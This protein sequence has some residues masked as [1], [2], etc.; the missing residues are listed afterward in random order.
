M[1]VLVTGGT[2]FIGIHL[3]AALVARGW[4][5]RCLVRATSNRQPLAVYPVDYVVGHLQDDAAL[6]QAVQGMDLIFH[7]AGAT[8]ARTPAEFDRINAEGTQRLLAACAAAGTALRSFVYVSSIAAAG[9]SAS[10]APV[11]E[12][13]PPRPVG[14]YGKSKRRAEEA[15]L[16]AGAHMPVTVLRPSAIYGPYDT[17]FLDLF[18]TVKRGWLPCVGP[19]DLYVDICHVDDLV[20]GMI[21]AAMCP[22]A[23]GE[24][25]FLGGAPHTWRDIGR[26]IAR[27]MGKRAREVHLSRG[28]VL[29]VATLA[30]TWARAS[31]R[32]SLLSRANLLERL[33]PFWI[34]DSSKAERTF[35]YAPRIPLATGLAQTLQWYLDAGWLPR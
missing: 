21:A 14:P 5:V 35:G 34:F 1:Q 32:P 18:R 3:V 27:Q 26:E 33:Q 25:F 19:Q 13:D 7:L 10:T 29:S 23:Y 20:Q 24:V 6:R 15:V 8:K 30:D 9:P 28:L 22:A 11:T 16:S 12:D 2:G 17:D 4:R 31:G